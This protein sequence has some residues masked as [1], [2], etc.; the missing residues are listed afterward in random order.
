MQFDYYLSGHP[1]W[2]EAAAAE[3]VY[4]RAFFAARAVA[5]EAEAEHAAAFRAEDWA[6]AET[7]QIRT[8]AAWEAVEVIFRAHLR[9][10]DE[11]HRV[12]D[13][14]WDEYVRNK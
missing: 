14:L 6:A 11:T 12:V 5:L 2:E 3:E 4:S 13:T 9:A 7:A 1:A 10:Q 8:R